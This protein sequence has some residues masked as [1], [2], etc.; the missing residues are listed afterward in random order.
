[1]RVSA[2]GGAVAGRGPKRSC[3]AFSSG[4]APR[5]S[6]IHLRPTSSRA[7]ASGHECRCG[8]AARTAPDTAA[9]SHVAADDTAIG[10]AE[11][12]M[13]ALKSPVKHTRDALGSLTAVSFAG[14]ACSRPPHSVQIHDHRRG[15]AP[16]VQAARCND[17]TSRRILMF[18]TGVGQF[19]AAMSMVWGLSPSGRART[20]RRATDRRR[21][22]R[23]DSPNRAGVQDQELRPFRL[24]RR[25]AD[26]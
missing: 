6:G 22:F 23:V 13:A 11:V 24:G 18:E 7:P 15:P 9:S 14:C 4:E 12:A 20:P 16:P 5:R 10:R 17:G 25:C 19:R 8:R 2:I 1:M 3:S 26:W 21:P